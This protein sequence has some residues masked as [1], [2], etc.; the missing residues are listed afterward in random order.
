MS[1][2]HVRTQEGPQRV[3][4]GNGL[5]FSQKL[6]DNVDTLT[7]RVQK[8]K[9]SLLILDGG[10]GE[11]K[12]TLATHL[13]DYLQGWE[14]ALDSKAPQLAMGGQEFTR[15]LRICFKMG[16]LVI[17]YDEAGDFNKRGSISR[18][19]AMINRIFETFRAFRIIVILVLPSFHVL[20]SDLF[21][22]NIPR[23]LVHCHS[24]GDDYG[25]FSAYSLY[26]MMYLKHH[27]QKLVVKSHAYKLVEANFHGEFLDLPPARSKILDT[28]STKG[29]LE[30]L[31]AAEI[32]IEGLV[33]YYDLA[34]RVSRS[35]LW[36]KQAVSKLG[37][38]HKRVIDR[39]KYFDEQ[40]VATLAD[41]IAEGGLVEQKKKGKK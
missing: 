1:E 5:P 10:V 27:M 35:V 11:G 26:R 2:T 9:A 6:A 31:K 4:Y 20:D 8:G 7:L 15:K 18:F 34:M 17:I 16:L 14:I 29:K 22:K 38:E 41:L 30:T 32:K 3:L 28:T 21:D 25:S 36:V 33:S 23:L 19:N 39:R 13:A 37:L 40:I 24:R 12:T